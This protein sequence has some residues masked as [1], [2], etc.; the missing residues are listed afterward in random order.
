MAGSRV[1][2]QPAYMLCN[3]PF[4]LQIGLYFDQCEYRVLFLLRLTVDGH[5]LVN[6]YKVLNEVETLV[7]RF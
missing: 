3:R 4:G 1:R 6:N 5:F 2:H 7:I